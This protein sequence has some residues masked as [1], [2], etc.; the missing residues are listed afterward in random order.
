MD[1]IYESPDKGKTVYR[2]LLGKTEREQVK[3]KAFSFDDIAGKSVKELN[4]DPAIIKGKYAAG[5]DLSEERFPP[6]I[7]RALVETAGDYTIVCCHFTNNLVGLFKGAA[8]IAAWACYEVHDF[9]I[10]LKRGYVMT[11]GHETLEHYWL[12]DGELTQEYTR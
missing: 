1:Y 3:P 8:L 12:S 4:A 5:Y 2:R 6:A 9:S 7:P 10:N 11:T